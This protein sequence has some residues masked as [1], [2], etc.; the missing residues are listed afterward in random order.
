M[1]ERLFDTTLY[2]D[3][4]EEAR[5]VVLHEEF[6]GLYIE[7]GD[8]KTLEERINPSLYKIVDGEVF[9]VLEDEGELSDKSVLENLSY[10][11]E[12]A[13]KESKAAK[14]FWKHLIK[15]EKG[16][17]TVTISPSGGASSYDD[18][19]V[20][21][22]H[23]LDSEEIEFYGIPTALSPTSLLYLGVRISEF[24]DQSIL[25][26]DPEDL[27]EISI[28]INIPEG[29]DGPWDFMQ[30]MFP[31]DSNAWEAI[32]LG[33]PWEIKK[34]VKKEAKPIA[35]Q[36]SSKIAYAKTDLDFIYIGAWG[37]QMMESIGRRI[38]S[39]HCPGATNTSL[40]QKGDRVFTTDVFGNAR[41][42]KWEYYTGSCVNC[43]AKNVEVGPC[44]ICK[45]C[46]KIL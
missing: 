5:S 28:S 44:D 3:L 42:I 23:R 20:N 32:K 6:A 27:R 19:R 26:E 25:I 35:K 9:L 34:E 29:E 22:G 45:V 15:G 33:L 10:H 24:S 17:F 4:P 12:L 2:K 21:V 8:N 43:G 30:E 39:Q 1:A 38:N 31:L 37:E 36:M 40:L 18:A 41:E 14:S 16:A 13:K 11:S 7:A 46:E